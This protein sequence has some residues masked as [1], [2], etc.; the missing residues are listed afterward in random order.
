MNEHQYQLLPPLSDAEYSALKA[1]IAARGV[2]V[3]VEKD[4][5]GNT[6]DGFHREKICQELNI[7]F[8]V[9]IRVGMSEDEKIHHAIALNLERRHLD[10]EQRRELVLTLKKSRGWS[11]E[12][13]AD[14]VGVT[15]GTVRNDLNSVSQNYETELPR[16][17]GKDGKSYPPKKPRTINARNG[18]EA[19]AALTALN[20]IGWTDG[21]DTEENAP[22]IIVEAKRTI[23]SANR[24]QQLHERMR[25]AFREAYGDGQKPRCQLFNCAVEELAQHI[26]PESVDAIITDPPYPK[27][28]LDT[29]GFLAQFAA[30][31]L[32][33]GGS[34]LAMCGQSY[35]PEIM[36]QMDG[37]LNYYWPLCLWTP[38]QAPHLWTRKVNTNWKPVLWYVKGEYTGETVSDVLKSDVND[39]RFHEWGQ[40]E[41]GWLQLVE[42]FTVENELLVD[43]FVGGGTGAIVAL[44]CRRR[45][46]GAD[47]NA[48][49]IEATRKRLQSVEVSV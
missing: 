17:I 27:E 37:H 48:D 21:G 41:S 40:S 42:R 24:D 5:Q 4:E 11:N 7:D 43:P 20:V 22:E 29:Y 3:A 12:A 35:L 9:K 47:I 49:A 13:I 34:L 36:A 38:G 39:K 1:D 30:Y 15:E 46:I 25:N 14:A 33:P 26:E 16:T 2:M 10:S 19:Q 6:L 18:S 32:R 23:A 44:Q 28:Y 31:A 8:P 45:F